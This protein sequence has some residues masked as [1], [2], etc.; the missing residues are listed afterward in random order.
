LASTG[1]PLSGARILLV[2]VAYKPAVADVRESPAL[3]IID[4]LHRS[5]AE[6]AFTDVMVEN[7]WTS[8]GTLV[9]EPAP[10]ERDW[11]LVIAHTLHPTADHS[12]LS[13]VPILLDATYGLTEL[14]HRSVL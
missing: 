1:R 8:S 11:D 13:S 9:R 5:G 12:W 14:P 10:A 3:H 6:V 7:V 2:G 4:E